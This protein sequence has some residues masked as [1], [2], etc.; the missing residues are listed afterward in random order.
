MRGS[1]TSSKGG[2]SC[3]LPPGTGNPDPDD[4]PGW[5]FGKHKSTLKWQN[6]MVRR[7]W[8]EDHI[9]D[10]IHNGQQFRAN[11]LI[12]PQNPATRFVH[13]ETGQ[14]VVIDDI[15]KELLHVGGKGFLY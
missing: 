9:T 15:T 1:G 10:A 4:D 14:S 11:N 3:S 13:P 12:N 6:Q 2:G 8:T 7:G 5:K